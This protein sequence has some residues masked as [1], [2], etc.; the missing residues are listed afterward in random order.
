MCEQRVG[1]STLLRVALSLSS[2]F[3]QSYSEGDGHLY[4]ND[5]WIVR[6]PNSGAHDGHHFQLSPDGFLALADF[7]VTRAP[8]QKTVDKWEKKRP[9]TVNGLGDLGGGGGV[10]FA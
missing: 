5:G 3:Y 8:D 4:L 10:F 7:L 1:S 9:T 6:T 2:L